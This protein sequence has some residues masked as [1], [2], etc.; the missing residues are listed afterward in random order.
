MQNII[1]AM[2]ALIT[3]FKNGKVDTAKYEELIKRQIAQGIDVVVPVGTTGES[4]TLSHEEH[5]ECIEIAVATCKGSNVK[6]I[7]GA[8]SN[9]THEAIG[10]AQHAQKVGA[11]GLLSVAPYY[12]KPTQEGLYQHYKAIAS[13]VEIPFMIYNV[14]G[15]TGVD[16]E[17]DTAIRLFDDVSNIYA[18]KEATG[19]LERAIELSSKRPEFCVISGDD[20]IDFPMLA[21]GGKGIISVTANLL[22]NY[23]SKLVHSVFNKDFETAKKINDDLYAINKALFVE[24]NPIPIKAAM[25]LAGLISTLEYRLPLTPPS[26]ETMRKLEDVLKGYEVIK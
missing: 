8:G 21:N 18:I 1:G 10:I 5:R 15:R 7:A 12:N 4:A 19:S 16:I 13:S 3:P 6:V 11:D 25:Y 17:A 20:A 24:S 22:P 14:P 9:A 2:T 23:K 26:R